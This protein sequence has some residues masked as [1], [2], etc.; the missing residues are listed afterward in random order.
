MD[1]ICLI[2]LDFLIGGKEMWRVDKIGFKD[3]KAIFKTKKEADDWA[4]HVMPHV[5]YKIK[6]R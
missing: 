2:I 5:G 1:L 6:K 3:S 4:K